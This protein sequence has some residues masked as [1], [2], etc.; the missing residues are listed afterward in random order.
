[1]GYRISLVCAAACHLIN[2][3][4]SSAFSHNIARAPL[5]YRTTVSWLE[6][7][8][9]CVLEDFYVCVCV[10]AFVCVFNERHAPGGVYG[11]GFVLG[12]G[13]GQSVTRGLHQQLCVSCCSSKQ[14][15]SKGELKR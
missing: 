15:A 11:S 13:V 8:P 2:V 1:M 5:A 6:A 10:C 3:L 14:W 9:G 7:V 12:E 4:V